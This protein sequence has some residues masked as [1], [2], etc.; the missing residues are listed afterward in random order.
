MTM[1]IIRS[2]PSGKISKSLQFNNHPIISITSRIREETHSHPK[3]CSHCLHTTTWLPRNKRTYQSCP[4]RM[5]IRP[6][7][8]KISKNL[9]LSCSHLYH[10][11]SPQARVPLEGVMALKWCIRNNYSQLMQDLALSWTPIRN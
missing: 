3:T 11:K 1:K 7:P 2:H 10:P 4:L 5:A 6:P 8:T 9:A